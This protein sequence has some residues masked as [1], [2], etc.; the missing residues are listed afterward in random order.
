MAQRAIIGKGIGIGI[1]LFL[2]LLLLSAA[3]APALAVELT[4]TGDLTQ[5]GFVS[6]QTVPGAT[7]KLNEKPIRVDDQGRFVFGFGRDEALT[8]TLTVTGPDGTVETRPLTLAKRDYKIQRIEGLPQKYVSPPESVLKRIREENGRIYTIRNR[9]TDYGGVFGGFIWP[10]EG[11]VSGVYG[12]Q[13]VL[14]G[15]PKRP[16]F[17]IDIAAPTGTK[18]IAPAGG[19]VRM[20]EP[21]L[22]YTGGTIMLDHGHGIVSVFSHLSKL[23]AKVGDWVEQGVKIGEIGSTGRS[24]GPHLDWRVNWFQTRLDPE[25]LLPEKD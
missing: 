17:G 22:F 25:L 4:L 24:T 6:A 8:H 5:G 13:R 10:A 15:E 19:I 3:P 2:S 23:D 20:A 12:S 18:I 1:G 16:H 14:N 21:D 11:I 7:A 9:D